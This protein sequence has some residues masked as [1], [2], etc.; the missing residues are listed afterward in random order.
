MFLGESEN[1]I[2]AR[3]ASVKE[4]KVWV[5]TGIHVSDWITPLLAEPS[6]YQKPFTLMEDVIL[7]KK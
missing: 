4:R 7:G 2:I 5:S 3:L 1:E 6:V